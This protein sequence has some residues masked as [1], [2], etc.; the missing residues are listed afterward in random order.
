MHEIAHVPLHPHFCITQK[1]RD[2]HHREPGEYLQLVLRAL[3]D[4]IGM[5][6]GAALPVASINRR[7]TCSAQ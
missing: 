2:W 4:I 6:N 3:S 1:S 7:S 5:S